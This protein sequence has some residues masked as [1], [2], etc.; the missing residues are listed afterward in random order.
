MPFR[1]AVIFACVSAVIMSVLLGIVYTQVIAMLE[2]HLDESILQEL[3]SLRDDFKQDGRDSLIGLA[4]QHTRR[5]TPSPLHILV[6]DAE[7]QVIAGD[8]PPLPLTEGWQELE[9][10]KDSARPS[11]TFPHY[12]VIGARMDE[13]TYLHVAYSKRDLAETRGLFIWSFAVVLAASI[14]LSLVGGLVVGGV[15]MG[16]VRGITRVARAIMDGD[17]SQRISPSAGGRNEL[18]ELEE[19]LNLMLQRLEQLMENTRHISSSLSHD[20][21]SPLGRH[22]QRLEVAR[23]KPRTP[24][25]LEAVIDAAI[26]DIQN[27]LKIFDAMLRIAQ[28]EAGTSRPRFTTVALTEIA[29]NVLSAYEAVAEEQGKRITADFVSEASV[30]GDAS[31]LTQM[32]VNLVEN[33]L[34]H[35]PE[36]TDIG[37]RIDTLNGA[38]RIV[39]TDGGPGIPADQRDRVFRHFYR[40]DASRSSPGSGLGLS[41]VAA[42]VKEHDATIILADNHPGLQVSIIFPGT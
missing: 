6:Q 34:R 14:L 3:N 7:G 37:I 26:A 30:R 42:V 1:Y 38:P 15:L 8:L 40:L 36:T 5:S 19:S 31:L 35:A 13:N 22:L 11:E 29:E 25:E 12:R 2:R 21:R 17:L 27:V 18:V 4:R 20:L 10:P 28:I 32:L 39:V 41:F 23:L 24:S 16:H 33:S 9:L